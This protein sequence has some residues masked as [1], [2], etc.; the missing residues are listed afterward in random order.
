MD[1]IK[2]GPADGISKTILKDQNNAIIINAVQ[3][4]KIP[5]LLINNSRIM[6]AGYVEI[7]WLILNTHK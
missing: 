2:A 5:S 7:S 4:L 6:C 3:A 1:G